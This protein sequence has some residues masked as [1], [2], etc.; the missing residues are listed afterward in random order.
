MQWTKTNKDDTRPEN[1]TLLIFSFIH[2]NAYHSGMP[3]NDVY[4]DFPVSAYTSEY[5]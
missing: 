4:F 2:S 5:K 3:K 1:A